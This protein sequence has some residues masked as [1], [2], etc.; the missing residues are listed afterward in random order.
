MPWWL[1]SCVNLTGLKDAQIAGNTLL[2]DLLW[3]MNIESVKKIALTYAGGHHPIH[4]RTQ[5]E[6][7]GGR[8]ANLPLC[9]SWNI[10]SC[11]QISVLP[12][13]R[14]S[15]SGWNLHHP[16]SQAFVL[17]L[18]LMSS[19]PLVLRPSYSD[20]ITS[21]ARLVFQLMEAEC[22]TPHGLHSCLSQFLFKKSPFMLIGPG[23]WRTLTNTNVCAISHESCQYQCV[24]LM[25]MIDQILYIMV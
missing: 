7:K 3:E 25:L 17:G 5:I 2:L 6:E 1:I 9:L 21:P 4:L 10:N 16:S 23:L 8:R 18:R 22:G 20:W 24:T 13:L 11:P 19:D 15:D 14:P 12:V